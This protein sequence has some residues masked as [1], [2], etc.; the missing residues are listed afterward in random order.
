LYCKR[1]EIENGFQDS[2]IQPI[3]QAF[4]DYNLFILQTIDNGK[5][6]ISTDSLC[7]RFMK[8]AKIT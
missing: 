3:R 4:R 7:K 8:H 1:S 5:N 2:V 6:R